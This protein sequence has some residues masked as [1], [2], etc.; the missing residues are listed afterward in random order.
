M[1]SFD[2]VSEVDMQE[3]DN[4]LNQVQ[5]VLDTRYDLKDSGCEIKQ[6]KTVL[7]IQAPDKMKLDALRGILHEKAAKR[8]ISVKS[9]VESEPETATGGSFRQ[10]IEIKQG[11]GAE[12]ARNIVKTIKG[13]NLK[14][15][16]AQINDDLVRVSAPKRDDLQSVIAALKQSIKNIDL[17]FKNFRD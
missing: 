13:F 4:A 12:D 5:K 11:I 3:V 9:F 14:K 7:T 15:V 10:K 8:G 6:D 16:Q 2:V 1:P 17:Q